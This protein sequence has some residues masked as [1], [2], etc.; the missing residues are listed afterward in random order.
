MRGN[1][2]RGVGWRIVSGVARAL[3]G[4]AFLALG[5]LLLAQ[6]PALAQGVDIYAAPYCEPPPQTKLLYSNRGYLILPKPANAPAFF[7]Y[8]QILGTQTKVE[9]AGQ[10]LFDDG[11]DRWDLASNPDGLGQLWP[12]RP[13]KKFDLD[14]VDGASGVHAKVSFEVLGLEPVQIGDKL[15]RSWKIR[16]LDHADDGTTFLQFLWY[17]PELCTLTEFTDSQHRLVKLL[18]VLKPGDANYDRPV[19]RKKGHLYFADTNEE[20][21]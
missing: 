18:R 6:I 3:L 7:Y 17:A 16:R 19:V 11:Q 8:Y 1:G 21:K 4:L 9:R 2:I 10:L 12:L 14:R 15:Y 5:Q 20:V 13:Q